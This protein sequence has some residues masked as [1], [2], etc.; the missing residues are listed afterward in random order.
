MQAFISHHNYWRKARLD[1]ANHLY[2]AGTTLWASIAAFQGGSNS[3]STMHTQVQAT[4]T[5]RWCEE[6][7]RQANNCVT[8]HAASCPCVPVGSNNLLWKPPQAPLALSALP[9]HWNL[10]SQFLQVHAF[11][12]HQGENSSQPTKSQREMLQGVKCSPPHSL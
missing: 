4:D 11:P 3:P 12:T 6:G 8:Q 10:C 7:M 1:R 5:G 2:G 9:V